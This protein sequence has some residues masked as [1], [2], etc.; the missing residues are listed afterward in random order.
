MSKEGHIF[1]NL[2]IYFKSCTALDGG[3]SEENVT[4]VFR[5]CERQLKSMVS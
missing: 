5:Y 3:I 4:P 1:N 2:L